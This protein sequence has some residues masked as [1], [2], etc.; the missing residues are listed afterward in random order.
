M[1]SLPASSI[2]IISHFDVNE[3]VPGKNQTKLMDLID[4][5]RDD[6]QMRGTCIKGEKTD[7]QCSFCLWI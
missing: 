6:W 3:L 5:W 2:V 1:S 7:E 4:M